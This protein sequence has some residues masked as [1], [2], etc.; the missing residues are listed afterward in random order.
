MNSQQD[1]SQADDTL[2]A[3]EV[4]ALQ[5]ELEKLKD[6]AARSQADLQNAKDRLVREGEEIRKYA[7]EGSFL[8]LLPSID[9]LNRALDHLPDDLADHDWAKG[10]DA[11]VKELDRH[12]SSLGLTKIQALGEEVDPE[13][14]DVL[15]TGEGEEGK[16]VE[17][18]ED[19]WEYHG[20]IL[21]PAK[22]KA[23]SGEG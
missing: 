14:H 5:V 21:R 20:K 16:V 4:A 22:V 1:T 15:Q 12:L 17:I 3:E 23:G 2:S 10:V 8:T 11:T 7:L 13:K 19:G 9:N 18:F 6:L